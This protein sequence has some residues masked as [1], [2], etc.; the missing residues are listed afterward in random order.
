MTAATPFFW[1]KA[2]GNASETSQSQN[3]KRK[4]HGINAVCES[5]EPLQATFFGSFRQQRRLFLRKQ[6]T[7][8]A[9]WILRIP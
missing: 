2:L 9:L 3:P 6:D 7:L 8:P 1:E 4:C 5:D